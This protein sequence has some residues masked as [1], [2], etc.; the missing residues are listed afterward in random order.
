MLTIVAAKQSEAA[1]KCYYKKLK[2][3][4]KIDLE[5]NCIKFDF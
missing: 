5:K 3:K 2:I 1:P 4:K